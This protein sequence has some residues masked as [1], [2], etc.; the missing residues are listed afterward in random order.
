MPLFHWLCPN[1]ERVERVLLPER[2]KEPHLC[3]R[4]QTPMKTVT[5]GSTSV[6]DTLDNG[7]MSKKLVR[8]K[9]AEELGKQHARLPLPKDP[10]IV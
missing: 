1:C 4:C 10:D 9:D 6:M 7:V 5:G 8:Y 3:D 2:P